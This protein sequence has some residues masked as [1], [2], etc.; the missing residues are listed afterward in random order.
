MF[1]GATSADLYTRGYRPF[2]IVNATEVALAARFEFT[3]DNFD[4]VCSDLSHFSLARAVAASSL[5]PVLLTPIT[6]RNYMDTCDRGA[7]PH[8]SVRPDAP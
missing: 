4:E 3:Q 5:V 1:H 8:K 2:L 7:K 6:V